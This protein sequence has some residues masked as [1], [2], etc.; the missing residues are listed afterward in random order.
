MDSQARTDS[1]EADVKL[2]S[3]P[4]PAAGGLWQS[5]GLVGKTAGVFVSVGTQGGGMEVR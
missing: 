1:E 2:P 5:G 4:P 3:P